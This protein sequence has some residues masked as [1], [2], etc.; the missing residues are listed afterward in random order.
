MTS[1]PLNGLLQ[2]NV[3]LEIASK[4][5]SL[6]KRVKSATKGDEENQSSKMVPK[7]AVV[8]ND[9]E[10]INDDSYVERHNLPNGWIENDDVEFSEGKLRSKHGT[11]GI[12]NGDVSD[13]RSP[14]LCEDNE[15][16]L[17]TEIAGTGDTILEEGS[18][19]IGLQVFFP[20]L[21][22]GFGTVSAGILLDVVQVTEILHLHMINHRF[23]K[24]IC[25][26]YA[27]LVYI[28]NCLEKS[29]I[30]KKLCK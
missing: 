25:V 1:P 29:P 9:E 8:L 13:Q 24:L 3:N 17:Q 2:Y 16:E 4:S 28:E 6:R 19:T 30:V 27:Q 23:P 15:D 20:F 14:L 26:V 11:H 12:L 18:F 5:K 21:I 7:I 10:D 22:A